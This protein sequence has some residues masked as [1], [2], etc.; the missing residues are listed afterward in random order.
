MPYFGIKGRI[1]PPDQIA[2]ALQIKAF[3]SFSR[4]YV[5]GFPISGLCGQTSRPI[6]SGFA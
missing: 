5:D 3:G 6:R 4:Q 2:E 1:S